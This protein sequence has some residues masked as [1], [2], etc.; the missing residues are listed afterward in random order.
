MATETI[1]FREVF[2]GYVTDLKLA[3]KSD[4]RLVVNLKRLKTVERSLR[5]EKT[6]DQS[7]AN[8]CPLKTK[9]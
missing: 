7:I 8:G 3:L 2:F 9:E 4:P 6:M 5:H 1:V